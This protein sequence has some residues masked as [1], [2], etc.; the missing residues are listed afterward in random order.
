MKSI[1]SFQWIIVRLTKNLKIKLW[2]IN[3]KS[4]RIYKWCFDILHIGHVKL[5][6]YAKKHCDFLI[7]GLNSD[8]SVNLLKGQGRPVNSQI[9]RKEILDS[10]KYIDKVVIFD[11]LTP[12]NLIKNILPDVL[13]KGSDYEIKDIVG[14]EI[15][16]SHGGKVLRFSL[17]KGESTSQ[18]IRDLDNE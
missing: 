5:F 6:E 14:A 2:K 4:Y 15:V 3:R 18:K 8:Q 11:E 7:V 13:I 16:K 9:N 12:E 1:H 17:I 10:I